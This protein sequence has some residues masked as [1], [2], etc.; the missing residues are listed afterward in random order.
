MV[1]NKSILFLIVIKSVAYLLKLIDINIHF[2]GPANM[3]IL[4][5]SQIVLSLITFRNITAIT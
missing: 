4:Y 5:V 1:F 3:E 2:L